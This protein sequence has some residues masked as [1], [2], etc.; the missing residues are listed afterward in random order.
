MVAVD[1]EAAWVK[2]VLST[3]AVREEDGL[4]CPVEVLW[5]LPVEVALVSALEVVSPW[6]DREVLER[7][8][9]VVVPEVEPPEEVCL[10]TKRTGSDC[11]IRGPLVQQRALQEERDVVVVDHEEVSLLV[12]RPL[13]G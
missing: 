12:L 2:K 3:F 5:T 9:G 6:E 1:L 11:E 13:L 4:P 10:S 8:G 7:V